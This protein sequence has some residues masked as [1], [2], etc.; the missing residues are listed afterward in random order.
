[1]S[2]A[3]VQVLKQIKQVFS[4]S[5]RNDEIRY[6]GTEPSGFVQTS[7]LHHASWMG[8]DK[9]FVRNKQPKPPA[10]PS[11]MT[12]DSAKYFIIYSHVVS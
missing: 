8:S 6:P 2:S 9:R 1:M 3:Q 11:A 5:G 7:T 4:T 10:P 12:D